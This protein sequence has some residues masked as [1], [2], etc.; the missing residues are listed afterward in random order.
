MFLAIDT[1]NAVKT[2]LYL[3]SKNFVLNKR[4]EIERQNNL[5]EKLLRDIDEILRS[6]SANKQS[7]MGIFVHRGPGSYTGLRIGLST[8]NFIAYSLNIPVIGYEDDVEDADVLNKIRAEFERVSHGFGTPVVPYYKMPPH[9]TR[10][11]YCLI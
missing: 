5:S 2:K 11:K 1:T 10:K 3:L 7:T 9:I 8:A 6:N 4:V